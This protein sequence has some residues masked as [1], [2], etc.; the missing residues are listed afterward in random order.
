MPGYAAAPNFLSGTT[1]LPTSTAEGFC[2]GDS[3]TMKPL[4][5]TVVGQVCMNKSSLDPFENV[6]GWN[7]PPNFSEQH[8]KLS[9]ASP[10][11][12]L[13]D[14][15]A[16]DDF[17]CAIKNILLLSESISFPSFCQSSPI[18]RVLNIEQLYHNIILLHIPFFRKTVSNLLCFVLYI[19]S[20]NAYT[21]LLT[22]VPTF[23]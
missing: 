7:V 2:V 22:Q 12:W 13:Y 14:V 17:H 16:H 6:P 9:I 5:I 23:V 18:Q 8:L 15:A 20:Y 1:W 10:S 4:Q 3:R 19:T 21:R 11:P